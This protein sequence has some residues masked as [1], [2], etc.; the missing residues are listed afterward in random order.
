MR[1]LK[2]K[3]LLSESLFPLKNKSMNGEDVTRYSIIHKDGSETDYVWC[4]QNKTNGSKRDNNYG[5]SN[6]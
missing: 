2:R 3:D 6:L 5:S 1:N 4:E